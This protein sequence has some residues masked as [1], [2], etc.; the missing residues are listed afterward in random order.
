MGTFFGF[1]K[2]TASQSVSGGRGESLC[3]LMFD[4]NERQPV[5]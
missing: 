5:K 1:K 3:W 2:I 4:R